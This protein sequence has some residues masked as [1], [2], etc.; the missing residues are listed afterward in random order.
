MQD[1]LTLVFDVIAITGFGGIAL[2]AFWSHHC[3]WMATY[4]PPLKPCE[5]QPE[6]H[7][8]PQQLKGYSKSR[9]R[10]I[11]IAL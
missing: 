10:T 1:L 7:S 8:E 3:Q 11:T 4:C 9:L 6:S 2:H 5:P